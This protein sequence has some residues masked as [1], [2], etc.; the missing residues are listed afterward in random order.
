MK[1][2]LQNGKLVSQDGL[3]IDNPELMG[4]AGGTYGPDGK[5]DA[6]ILETNNS[7]VEIKEGETI[8]LPEGIEA[9]VVY[10]LMNIELDIPWKNC[11]ESDY[12]GFKTIPGYFTRQIIRLK[13]VEKTKC[14]TWCGGYGCLP[15]HR[16]LEFSEDKSNCPGYNK[17]GRRSDGDLMGTQPFIESS[18]VEHK[19]QDRRITLAANVISFLGTYIHGINNGKVSNLSRLDFLNACDH[20]ERL[21]GVNPEFTPHADTQES[22]TELWK[23]VFNACEEQNDVSLIKRLS[24]QFTITRKA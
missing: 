20:F 22:Q 15:H 7:V 8:D 23:E 6:L 19:T 14:E 16:N 13:P 18:P 11:S 1:L 12:N 3:E 4:I 24:E 2:T 17:T 9:E 5:I 10:Q 21:K